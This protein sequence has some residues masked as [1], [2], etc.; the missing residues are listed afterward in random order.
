MGLGVLGVGFLYFKFKSLGLER[1]L[2][3]ERYKALF[4]NK[5]LVNDVFRVED[6]FSN[7]NFKVLEGKLATSECSDYQRVLSYYSLF[8]KKTDNALVV[9]GPTGSG[10]TEMMRNIFKQ[11]RKENRMVAYVDLEQSHRRAENISDILIYQKQNPI[12]LKKLLDGFSDQV[13]NPV[14]LLDNLQHLVNMEHSER[15]LADL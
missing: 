6:H 12:Y 10:K 4:I 14:V 9:I 3:M 2:A 5:K 11:L 15:I 1:R 7:N 8:R 13:L